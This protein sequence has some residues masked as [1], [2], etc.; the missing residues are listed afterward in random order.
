MPLSPSHPLLTALPFLR[1]TA[2]HVPAVLQGHRECRRRGAVAGSSHGGVPTKSSA[3][4]ALECRPCGYILRCQRARDHPRHNI[5]GRISYFFKGRFLVV[6]YTQYILWVTRV[7]ILVVLGILGYVPG[8]QSWLFW[9]HSG[10]YPGT[11]R[12]DMYPTS[13]SL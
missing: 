7:P 3:S 12:L 4:V 8:Y 10:R 1:R 2:Q 11:F 5:I 6:G 9:S 13:T